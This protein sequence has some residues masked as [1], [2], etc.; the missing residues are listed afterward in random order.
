MKNAIE[1]VDEIWEDNQV[2]FKAMQIQIKAFYDAKP[3]LDKLR[4]NFVRR[5]VN[6]RMNLTEILK[7]VVQSPVDTDP[8]ELVSLCKQALDEANHY[9]MVRDAIEYITG[10]PLDLAA[11][12][13]DE[14]ADLTT[15]GARVAERFNVEHDP[16]A[17]G[18]YQMIVEGN[19]S[20]NWQVM[21]D[22]LTDPMLSFSYA[23]IAAD[24]RFHAKLGRTHL[25]KILDTAEKQEYA[26]AMATKMRKFLFDINCAGNIPITES[27]E[28]IEN[29]Y[30]RGWVTADFDTVA[31]EAI[32]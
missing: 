17:R 18:L 9:R 13:P 29:H 25:A 12:V 1:F 7:S 30:G 15:K 10:E 27:R 20:C 19:A 24:E 8:V 3:T 22:N 14:L 23:K 28:M 16:I 31:L 11:V 2:L 21:A 4:K 5:M 26:T 32:Y 6:E